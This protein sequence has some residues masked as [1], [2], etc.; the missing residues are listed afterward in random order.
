MPPASE[1]SAFHCQTLAIVGVGL[2]GGAIARQARARG[3]ALT[4]VG[5]GRSVE[6]LQTAQRTGIID[7]FVTDPRDLEPTS[8]AVVCTPV[9]RIVDDVRALAMSP[10]PPELITDVGSV[11]AAVCEPLRD[12][13]QFVGSHPLAG[14]EKRGF[15]NAWEVTLEGRVCVVE[16]A[17]NPRAVQHVSSFWQSLGMVI[18]SMDAATHDDVLARTSHF[19]HLSAYGLALLLQN[20]DATFAASGFRDATRI[21]AS[22]PDLWTGILLANA[23]AVRGALQQHQA[24]LSKMDELLADRDSDGL[25][26]LL[27]E[28][29]RNR[30]RLG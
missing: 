27:G 14:S 9:D 25:R 19:P 22:D 11:K 5:V 13:S 29:Q 21:A 3:A 24:T 18:A 16:S 12:V 20:G 6:R 15:E 8:L 28:A 30:L 1:N 26:T 17:G 2:L 10:N 23:E 4:I 7:R